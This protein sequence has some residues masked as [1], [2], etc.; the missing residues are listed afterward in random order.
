MGDREPL[1]REK[2]TGLPVPV[3]MLAGHMVLR[4]RGGAQG[5]REVGGWRLGTQRHPGMSVGAR[6]PARMFTRSCGVGGRRSWPEW[7]WS[8]LSFPAA[9]CSLPATAFRAL[10]ARWLFLS[11]SREA[12]RSVT[13]FFR[14]ISV[15][16]WAAAWLLGFLL[17]GP[18]FSQVRFQKQKPRKLSRHCSL[19]FTFRLQGRDLPAQGR[20]HALES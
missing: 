11:F 12:V 20:R 13:S 19:C 3:L 15:R 17:H 14:H 10:R 5:V 1:L 6:L 9:Q 8:S 2:Q 7:P 4:K 16:G 18:L